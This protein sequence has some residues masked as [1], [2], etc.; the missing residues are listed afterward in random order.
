MSKRSAKRKMLA[1]QDD[2]AGKM[3]E[4][5]G[6]RRSLY[7]FVNEVLRQVVRAD[8]MGR[9]LKDVVDEYG[10][11]ETAKKAGFTLV[12][13]RLWRDIVDW[14]FAKGKRWMTR[15]WYDT[16]G[17]YAKFYSAKAPKDPLKAF[18]RNLTTL[19]WDVSEFNVS[20]NDSD[21]IVRCLCAKFSPAY[22]ELFSAF[23]EGTLNALGYKCVE[24]EMSKG[25]IQLIF[26]RK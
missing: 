23:L 6:P 20:K 22:T 16:G 21:I 7:N 15:K 2:L 1:V 24:K 9:T 26:R 8:D 11:L 25:I 5:A 13:E 10:D 12:S 17:W 3:V 19:M 14:A 18:E 4:I